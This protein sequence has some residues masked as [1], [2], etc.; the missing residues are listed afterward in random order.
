VSAWEVLFHNDQH[1]AVSADQLYMPAC[2]ALIF[3]RRIPEPPPD[4]SVVPLEP[5]AV[6]AKKPKK[7]SRWTKKAPMQTYRAYNASE[8]RSVEL[9]E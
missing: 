6:V 8:W 5:V 1:I 3:L 2:G 9:I 7:P 4:P